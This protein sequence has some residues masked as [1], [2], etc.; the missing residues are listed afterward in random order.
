MAKHTEISTISLLNMLVK[1]GY[2]DA[3]ELPDGVFESLEVAWI[4]K[5]SPFYID[6]DEGAE[7]VITSEIMIA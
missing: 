3:E 2:S 6:S 5:G 7:R 4:P 1:L